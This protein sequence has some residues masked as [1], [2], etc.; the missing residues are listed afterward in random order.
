MIFLGR[1]A[2]AFVLGGIIGL[3]REYHGRPAG[4]RTHILVGF[5]SALIMLVSI[6]GLMDG[7]GYWVSS[8]MQM[9][10]E[11]ILAL[12]RKYQGKVTGVKMGED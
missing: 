3:E 2:L 5:G 12:V 11:A 4:L 8:R 1:L 9:K 7:G 10:I 6:Y